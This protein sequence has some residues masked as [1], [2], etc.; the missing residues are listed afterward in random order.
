MNGPGQRIT[1][2]WT[3]NGELRELSFEPLARLLDVLR[4]ELDL[5]SLK[6]GCGEGECGACSLI[7]GG[8]VR[9]ACLT[10]AA[11]LE[12]GA[13]LLTAEGLEREP[14]GRALGEAFAEDGAVQCGYCTPGLMVGS[15]ALLQE[16]PSP[17]ET[18]IRQRLAGHLCR[19]TGYTKIIEAVRDAA[20]KAGK[21][22]P[23]GGV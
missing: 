5:I 21:G 1:R 6:E 4:E 19:C 14:L 9:L 3:V 15:Y 17:S 2:R 22:V 16:A 13:T 11:Q 8:E 20:R 7:V 12:D 18:E 23:G 10:A